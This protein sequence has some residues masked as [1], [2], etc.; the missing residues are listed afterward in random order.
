MK[1]E[2]RLDNITEILETAREYNLT[3]EEF[4]DCIETLQ[5]NHFNKNDKI[6]FLLIH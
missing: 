6:I 2:W 1:D 5:K 3:V 4:L